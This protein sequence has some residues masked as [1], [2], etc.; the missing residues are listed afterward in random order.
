MARFIYEF[1]GVRGR[2]LKLYDTKIVITTNVTVGSLLTGNVTD[3]EKTLFLSDVVGVQF[4]RSGMLLIGYLQFETPSMQMNNKSDNMFSENTFTF[5][6]NKND[7]T[8]EL[9]KALYDYIVD[10][11]EEIKCG[12]KIFVEPPNFDALKTQIAAER[13][14]AAAD[15][16]V[17]EIPK[18]ESIAEEPHGEICELC[19]GHYEHLTYCRIKDDFGTRFRNICDDCIVKHRAITKK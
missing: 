8:N 13:E 2:N 7:I 10:R 4:K 6:D 5:E 9:M 16:M 12:T 1:E 11:I 14:K 17:V 15:A 19:G 3:G 18:E